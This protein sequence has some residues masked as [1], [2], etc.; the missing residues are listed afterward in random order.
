MT[1]RRL[2]GF[3]DALAAGRRPKRFRADPED[4]EVLRTA[5]ALRTARPGESAP[6]ETF[7][8]GLFQQLSEQASSGTADEVRP[9]ARRPRR[10]AVV[11]IA[12]A[13][14]LVSGTAVVTENLAQNGPNLTAAL[15]HGT[16]L[17]TGSFQTA[18]SKVF[19]QI[20]AYHGNPSW[21]FMNVDVPNYN[22]QLVCTLQVDDGSTVA[23]GAFT[24]HR[25]IGQ[26]SRTL[27][28][29]NVAQLR[30]AKLVTSTGSVVAAATFAG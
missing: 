16:A 8:S 7:V 25:G 6:S 11:A 26:F 4:V 9:V 27:A 3:I 29:V 30:G 18:D 22:G 23:F 21:V 19:G 2:F 20:V 28:G 10:T 5:I 14:V 1:G 13:A 15:P 17:R 12:A 24:L